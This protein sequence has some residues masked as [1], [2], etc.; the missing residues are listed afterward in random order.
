[1]NKQIELIKKEIRTLY[2][3][4]KDESMRVWF[5]KGHVMLVARYAE[6]IAE[7]VG[8]DKEIVILAALFHDIARAWGVNKNPALMEESLKKAEEMMKK[9][10]YL[11]SQIQ[12]VKEAILYHSCRKK[13]PQVEEGRVLAT[14]DA[15]AHFLSEFYLILPV[16]C[17]LTA[18]KGFEEYREWA[19]EKIER[20][21]HK[22]IFYDEYREKVRK[23]YE[24]L[25]TVLITSHK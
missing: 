1:M 14:A 18:V 17:W 7:K 24:A 23:N 8:A 2:K 10:S 19:L 22:K 12:K 13:L 20:D 9:Y 3:K 16:N 25:K 5:F 21:F 4:S 11:N 6:E 15:L